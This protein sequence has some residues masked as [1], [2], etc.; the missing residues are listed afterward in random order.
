[1]ECELTR[2]RRQLIRDAVEFARHRY[3]LTNPDGKLNLVLDKLDVLITRVIES[4]TPTPQPASM[5][6]STISGVT[7][8]LAEAMADGQSLHPS[9]HGGMALGGGH[10]M[11][12][13][14]VFGQTDMTNID[15]S[16]MLGLSPAVS[17]DAS[18]SPED[19][20]DIG[21]DWVDFTQLFPDP[22]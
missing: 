4:S 6:R 14:A 11:E 12:Q 16:T 5:R 1:M 13:Q 17:Q 19:Y 15:F 3:D 21:W 20:N 8:I 22:V 9:S 7:P 2:A 10:P 18:L